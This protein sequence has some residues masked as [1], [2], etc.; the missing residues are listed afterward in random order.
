MSI[1]PVFSKLEVHPKIWGEE[2]W[3]TNNSKYFIFGFQ[4]LKLATFL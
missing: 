2:L 4:P 1:S 3:I